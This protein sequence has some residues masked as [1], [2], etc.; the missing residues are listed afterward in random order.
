MRLRTSVTLSSM[1][2]VYTK[3]YRSFNANPTLNP[4][5]LRK[6]EQ[7]HRTLEFWRTRTSRQLTKEDSR[8]ITVNMPQFPRRRASTGQRP[9]QEREVGASS[10]GSPRER[11]WARKPIN[12]VQNR[13]EIVPFSSFEYSF[14]QPGGALSQR[15]KINVIFITS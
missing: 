1:P 13:S 4:C 7:I 5:Q 12:R 10:P 15:E 14:H 2:R 8:Q 11:T 3:M 9:N 6:S